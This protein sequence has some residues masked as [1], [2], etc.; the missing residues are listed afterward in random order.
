M[1]AQRC[2]VIIPS[3]MKIHL[4]LILALA[5]AL[6]AA[7]DHWVATW[8]TAQALVRPAVNPNAPA[9][10]NATRSYSNQT[11]RMI[12][13]TSI[14]GRRLR[15]QLSNAFGNTPVTVG[16]AHIALRGK[17]SAIVE[18]SDRALSFS[19]K[20]ETTIRPG[21]V[22]FSDPVEFNVPALADVAVSLYFPGETGPPT[23]H[24]T[25]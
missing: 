14:P 20:P 25:A 10:P 1:S 7:E 16:A 17:E 4:K 3:P 24:A 22:M 2:G 12:V 6:L 8:T 13:R 23:T 21:V 18:G 5:P 19:G 11:I 9:N 15:V